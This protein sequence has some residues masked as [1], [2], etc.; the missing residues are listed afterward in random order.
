M[1]QCLYHNNDGSRW[2][3]YLSNGKKDPA[4]MR[5]VYVR[6]D[7]RAS[8]RTVQCWESFGNFAVCRIDGSAHLPYAHG[9]H[10][11]NVMR[12]HDRM[13]IC[14]EGSLREYSDMFGVNLTES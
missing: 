9:H 1:S 11:H 4:M 10:L 8:V 5:V 14:F 7:G 6:K 13:A 12:E 3:Y 2:G